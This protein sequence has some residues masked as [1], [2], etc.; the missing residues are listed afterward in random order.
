MEPRI[1][2]HG[3]ADPWQNPVVSGDDTTDW[4]WLGALLDDPARDRALRHALEGL[5]FGAHALTEG[6][7]SQLCL[8]PQQL[9]YPDRDGIAGCRRDRLGAAVPALLDH[10]DAALADAGRRWLTT[11]GVLYEI[12]PALLEEWL[13]RDDELALA[14][15][16]TLAREG[17]ALLGPTALRRLAEQA[18]PTTRELAASWVARIDG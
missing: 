12:D 13:R 1:I 8:T 9:E 4:G 11:P 15:A 7:A 5:G 10:P 18:P 16:P 6:L 2:A 17:L 3:V 14:V